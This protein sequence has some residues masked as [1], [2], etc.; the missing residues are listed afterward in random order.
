PE[1]GFDVDLPGGFAAPWTRGNNCPA[2]QKTGISPTAEGLILKALS[3]KG[4]HISDGEIT[5]LMS[6]IKL[7]QSGRIYRVKDGVL[8]DTP[9]ADGLTARWQ[10]AI[11]RRD[12]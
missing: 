8:R 3:R 9:T 1:P 10:A 6:G 11:R 4:I 5:L 7:Q 12:A 2:E